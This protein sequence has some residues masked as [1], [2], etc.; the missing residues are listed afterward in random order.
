MEDRNKY[1]EKLKANCSF[2]NQCWT[3]K[4]VT[5][6]INGILSGYYNDINAKELM[7]MLNKPESSVGQFDRERYILEHTCKNQL[8]INPEHLELKIN[9]NSKAIKRIQK[10]SLGEKFFDPSNWQLPKNPEPKPSKFAD[11]IFSCEYGEKNPLPWQIR[12]EYKEKGKKDHVKLE[13]ILRKKW[14]IKDYLKKNEEWE[15]FYCDIKD[16]EKIFKASKLLLNNK[17]FMCKPDVVLFDKLNNQFIVIERKFTKVPIEKILIPKW[18]SA[19]GQLWCYSWIDDFIDAKNILL[20]LELYKSLPD[21]NN[22]LKDDYLLPLERVFKWNRNDQYHH[23]KCL[24]MF[25]RYGGIFK[26]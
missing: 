24:K 3:W 5:K 15:L 2:D 4:G 10:K 6:K 14:F 23:K 16:Y 19:Q 7:W 21:T 9:P 22:S 1:I 13:N 26:Q 12:E 17:A 11:W 25:E 20:I 18:S 8:C